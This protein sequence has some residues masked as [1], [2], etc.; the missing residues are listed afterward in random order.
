M[1]C[2]KPCLSPDTLSLYDVLETFKTSGEDFAVV[3]N[4]YALVVGVVR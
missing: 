2:V 1:Y 3:V 4:E